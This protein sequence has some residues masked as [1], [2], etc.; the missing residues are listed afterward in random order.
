VARKDCPGFHCRVRRK[1]VVYGLGAILWPAAGWAAAPAI[2]ESPAAMFTFGG[3]GTVGLVHSDQPLADFTST[4]F[5]AVGA[6]HT[7]AWSAAVDSRIAAQVT[8]DVTAKL[9]A[10]LQVISKQNSDASFT[11]RVEWANVK[12]QFTPDFS[13]RA[14][15]TALGVFLLTDSRN[16]GFANPWVRPPFEVYDLVPVTSSDG[17]GF[18]FRRALAGGTNI[19]EGSVGRTS[20]SYPLPNSHHVTDDGEATQQ[21]SLVDTY[22]RGFATVRLTY[23]QGHITLPALGSLFNAFRQFGPQGIGIAD[24]YDVD[25]RILTFFGVSGAY[26]P[27]DWF[28]MAEWGQ[29]ASHSVLGKS[30]GW[31]ISSGR[32]FGKFTPYATYAQVRPNSN[33]QDPGLDLASLPPAAAAAGIALNA[34]LNATLANIAS[35][36]TFSLGARVDIARSVDLKLQWDRTSLGKG[37]RGSL[38]NL[39][40]G[41]TPGSNLTLVS[42][43]LDFVF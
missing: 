16:I 43:T 41:F 32:R 15:R 11:P 42:A 29:V 22:Q 12:Y 23:G 20:Y 27:G 35:Q 37:S 8:A 18:N 26:E 21:L 14:G 9:S 5:E 28:L 4:P 3:F 7:H 36:S 1:L 10:V 31:Y 39:Q 30:T 13:V 34:G 19:V 17:F 38:T 24:R 25:D 2:D 40:P 6:G 33:T